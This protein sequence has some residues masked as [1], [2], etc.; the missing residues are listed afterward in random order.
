[1]RGY[2]LGVDHGEP[3]PHPKSLIQITGVVSKMLGLDIDLKELVA[4]AKDL[5]RVK[6][7]EGLPEVARERSGIYG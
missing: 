5:D 3:M 7:Q 1:M 2:K 6:P 4:R